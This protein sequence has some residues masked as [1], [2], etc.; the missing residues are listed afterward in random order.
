VTIRRHSHSH[1]HG[2]AL[3]LH[4]AADGRI[5]ADAAVLATGNLPFT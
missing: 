2:R 5:D 4:L 3:R 1:S